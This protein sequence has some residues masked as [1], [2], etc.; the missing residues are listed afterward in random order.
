[1][2]RRVKGISKTYV[3]LGNVAQYLFSVA[4]NER[5][6]SLL[7][8]QAAA[9]FYAFT[10]EAYLN[11]VGCEEILFWSEIERISYKN[12]LTVIAK[13]LNIELDPSRR[14]F[15]TIKALFDLRNDLRGCPFDS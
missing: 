4:K 5:N 14:P 3:D 8:L 2:K 10:F 15:Q 12:K 11:H 9:V 7:N 6:G 13:H 1:M